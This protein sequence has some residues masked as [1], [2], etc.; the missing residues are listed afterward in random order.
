MLPLPNIDDDAAMIRAGRLHTLRSA[1][2]DACHRFRDLASRLLAGNA[3][4]AELIKE[5]RA[6]L[7]R[8]E[9]IHSMESR[10]YR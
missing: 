4:D 1:R 8:M 5:A 7:D 10:V 3:D 6:I 2:A 9:Q